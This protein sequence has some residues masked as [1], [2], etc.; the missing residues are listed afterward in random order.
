[1]LGFLHARA[2]WIR[3]FV[4]GK[5]L[6]KVGTP[7]TA[8]TVLD[9]NHAPLSARRAAPRGKLDDSGT[10]RPPSHGYLPVCRGD[11]RCSDGA[12]RLQLPLLAGD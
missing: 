8:R 9:K 4:E 2:G 3:F 11:G 1:M 5:R 10:A 6:R 12:V 7:A